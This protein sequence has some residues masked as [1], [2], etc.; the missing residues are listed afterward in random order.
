MTQLWFASDHHLNHENIL[1][2]KRPDGSPLRTFSTIEEHNRVIVERH[3][4]IVG[5]T[6]HV[7]FMGDVAMK[8]D[9]TI[10]MLVGAM[11]GRKRLLRGNHDIAKTRAYLAMGFEEIHGTRMFDSMLF[12]HIPVHPLSLGRWRGNIHGHIHASTNTG[13][14]ERYVNLSM[15]MIDYTPLNLQQVRDK[16]T[17]QLNAARGGQYVTQ[18][19]SQIRPGILAA[20]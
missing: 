3:N 19:D 8:I 2:F 16:L 10:R 17:A 20:G 12:S 7:Y 15:E 14:D 1:S 13:Y 6:D 11:N 18:V 5:L 9:E 4:A